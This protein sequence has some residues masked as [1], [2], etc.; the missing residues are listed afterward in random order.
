M[1]PISGRRMC[2]I[3]RSRGW[4]LDRIEGSHHIFLH[5]DNP[6]AVSD[7]VHGNRDLKPKTQKSVMRQVG[8]TDQDL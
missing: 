1:K 3:L 8:F 7:P 2:K 4:S 5:P 6:F